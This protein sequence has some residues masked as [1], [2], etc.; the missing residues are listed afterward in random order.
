MSPCSK[1][2]IHQTIDIDK[3]LAETDT[4]DIENSEYFANN[5]ELIK[6]VEGML[7]ATNSRLTR[8]R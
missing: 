1:Y 4:A 6:L 5:F 2:E 7:S 3:L 8:K